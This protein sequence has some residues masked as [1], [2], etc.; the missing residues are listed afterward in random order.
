VSIVEK[1]KFMSEH[2]TSTTSVRRLEDRGLITGRR[3]YVDDLKAPEGRPPVAFMAVVRSP[4]AHARIKHIALEAARS[5]PG[6]IAAFTGE[7]L[8]G[9]MPTLDA[10][11]VGNLK[12]PPRK[13]LAVDKVRYMGDPLAIIL[14][15]DRYIALDARDLVDVDYEP[16]TAVIDPETA[17]APDA[18]LL[19]EEFGS[20]QA[21]QSHVGGG[22]IEAA[23]AQA[24]HI[25]HLRLV[26]QRLAPSSIEPRGCLFDFDEQS[27]ILNAWMSSQAVYRARQTLAT[28]LKLDPAR[29]HI[30]NA[31][32]GGAFGAKN[33]LLGEEIIA[34]A[35]AMRFARPVK[36]CDDRSE[37]LQ[38]Q[39][40]GRGQVSYVEAAVRKDGRLL[41]LKVRTIA[42]IGAFIAGVTA[43]IHHRSATF[44]SG[45]Y[46]IEAID[47]LMTGV[48]TNKVP[49]APYRGAGRPEAA[50]LLERTMD[51]VAHELQLDAAEVRRRNFIPP[52]AFPYVTKTGVTYDSG[53]Y[54]TTLEKA[55]A[56]SNYASYREQ[57]RIRRQNGGLPLLGIGLATFIELTGDATPAPEGARDSAIV[58]VRRDGTVLV[59]SGV[60]HSGQGHFT[61]FAR[62]TAQTLHLALEQIEVRMNDTALPVFSG[63]TVGSRITQTSGSAVLLAAEAVRE[64]ALHL[65]AH[66][67]EAAP[68]D[69]QLEQGQISV[70]GSPTRN[71]S[72]AELARLAEEQPDLLALDKSHHYVEG[73]AAWRD[74]APSGAAYASG[75]HIAVVEIDTETGEITILKYV[76]VDDCGHV[77]NHEL[78]EGQ[79]HGGLAQGI[80]QAL[81]EEV[82]YNAEGQLLTSTLMDY[83]LPTASMV[84][85]FTTAFVETPSPT[86]PLGVKGVGEAG[87]LGG[88][89]AIVNAVLDALAP[90]GIDSIDMPLRPEKIW[91]LV[92]KGAV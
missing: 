87:C 90:L 32:V 36:W 53:N 59:Q 16:L 66:V 73:L 47:N 89:P 57:Q 33:F 39:T 6:V 48:Y 61:T 56:L 23:F 12:K 28:F 75:A 10:V 15:E 83:S 42:D 26:N 5:L 92:H 45:P 70:Q 11:P 14:A 30:Q 86:N 50:Y 7:E 88:P 3:H 21:F 35:L 52:E 25:V 8:V 51:R 80:S 79:I 20:N 76:A 49:T 91:A 43:M 71:I 77:L 85:T 9:D 24:D 22:D 4:Y 63:G 40:H 64:Q 65:A 69:L 27:G 82:L 46:R 2:T 34:A 74:F 68:A 37:S 81:Y 17:L 44:L 19:Y 29:I 55:L 84:P 38:A 78:A 60:S 41:G 54:A 58:R 72:L 31:E 67:L 1:G 13:P 62:I 18:P